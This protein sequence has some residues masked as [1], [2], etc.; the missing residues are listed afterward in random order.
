MTAINVDH[1]V[2]S[3]ATDEKLRRARRRVVAIRF[4]GDFITPF[5]SIYSKIYGK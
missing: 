2:G 4:A 1:L 5:G 3:S